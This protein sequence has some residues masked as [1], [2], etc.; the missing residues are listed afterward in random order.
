M[1]K[2]SGAGIS[3][4]QYA[5]F[6]GADFSTDPSLVESCRSPLCTNIVA[7][8]GGTPRKR[9]GYRTVLRPG[10]TI[11]G[12][13]GAA[14]G[15]VQK[16][17]VHAG[18]KLY[19]WDE[20]GTCEELLSGLP[21]H[22]SRAAYLAGKL[23]IV[24]GGGF[25][26]YDGAV[27]TRVAAGG[28]YVPT[29]TITRSPSGGGVFYEAVNLLTPY[30]KNAFQTDGESRTFTLDADIDETGAVRAWVWGEEVSDFTL[31]RPAGT[32]TF[33][34]APAAPDAGASDG[35]VVE[36]PH[37]VEGYAERIDKCTILTTYGV[38]SNDRLVLSGNS[39]HPNIDWTSGLDDGS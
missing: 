26:T 7:D 3:R 6:R 1:G 22:K 5:A 21:R 19:L 28:A 27:A 4:T 29:T 34:A 15:G 2:K 20:S 33:A 14:F 37:T 16:R 17:L 10:D 31:D 9:L 35:L 12:I 38:G 18:T 8:A 32:I 13:Y 24:T 36:F 23:W 11:Y 25:F 39:E 30:R